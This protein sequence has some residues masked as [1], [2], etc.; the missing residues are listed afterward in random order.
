M[1]LRQVKK[2]LYVSLSQSQAEGL[3]SG[4]CLSA[5]GRLYFFFWEASCGS[6][7]PSPLLGTKDGDL[8]AASLSPRTRI[9]GTRLRGLCSGCSWFN[10]RSARR[11]C[12]G[13]FLL[14]TLNELIELLPILLSK[15]LHTG[16]SLRV[17]LSSAQPIRNNFHADRRDPPRSYKLASNVRR[18]RG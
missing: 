3:E 9:L 7:A 2:G 11:G 18:S 1:E 12:F 15:A 13:R 17:G 6:A 16:A 5:G 10:M 8:S 4:F 14:N